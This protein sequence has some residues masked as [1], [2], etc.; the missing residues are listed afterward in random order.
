[1]DK[2][3]VCRRVTLHFL[4]LLHFG[5]AVLVCCRSV[6]LYSVFLLFELR[7]WL[8]QSWFNHAKDYCSR[9][10]ECTFHGISWGWGDLSTDLQIHTRWLVDG[11]KAMIGGVVS[12]NFADPQLGFLYSV[13][14]GFFSPKQ[15]VL[16]GKFII[17]SKSLFSTPYRPPWHL[18]WWSQYTTNTGLVR[19]G[20]FP[21]RV[22]CQRCGRTCEW[23]QSSR[24]RGGG[25]WL[26][27]AE[28]HQLLG[29]H[30]WGVDDLMNIFSG[31]IAWCSM[32]TKKYRKSNICKDSS[33][34]IASF[35][36]FG[37]FMSL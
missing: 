36:S 2:I 22:E 12:C 10:A 14:R 9:I 1:M 37:H 4:A 32:F 25:V 20:P 16:S 21:P 31:C 33:Q 23:Q 19:P 26:L 7:I 18:R 17:S 5:Y 35:R 15:Q 30:M 24:S 8:K 3:G 34:W 6:Y 29:W 28:M 13:P 27:S 11:W